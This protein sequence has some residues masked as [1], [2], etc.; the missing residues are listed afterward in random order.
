MQADDYDTAH[1]GDHVRNL[2]G[3]VLSA[4]APLDFRSVLDIGCGTGALLRQVLVDRPVVTVSGLDLSSRMLEVARRTLGDR[5][6]LRVGDAERL[7]YENAT[8]DV[9]TC[10]D[11]FHHYPAP[12][13]VLNEMRRVLQPS[14]VFLL[15]DFWLPSPVRRPFNIVLRLLP[16]GDVRVYSQVELVRMALA[17]GFRGRAWSRA[18]RRGQLLTAG[19][20]PGRA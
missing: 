6:D 17:A 4:L 2:H 18:G 14:G 9:I 12:G 16:Y 7:P 8:F 20:L 5:I 11:S 15:A 3:H 1:W 19:P 10:V 13:A